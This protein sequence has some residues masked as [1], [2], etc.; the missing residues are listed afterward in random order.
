MSQDMSANIYNTI[1]ET[2]LTAKNKVYTAVNFAMAE[3]YW[4]IGKQIAEAQGER[5]EY[6]KQLL[7]YLSEQLTSEFGGGFDVRNLQNMRQFYLAFP[8]TNTLC[9]QLS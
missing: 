5:A 7:K 6:G 9:S 2:V 1:R 3:A 4:G 8:N